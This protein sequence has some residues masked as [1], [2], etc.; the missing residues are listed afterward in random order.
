MLKEPVP[1][2]LVYMTAWADEDGTVYFYHD[3][4]NR[5]PS[6]LDELNRYGALQ[7]VRMSDLMAMDRIMET[8]DDSAM[9]SSG[10]NDFTGV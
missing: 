9:L 2:H 5:D 3:L 4:Y 8:S 6:L 7:P 1:V 10:E